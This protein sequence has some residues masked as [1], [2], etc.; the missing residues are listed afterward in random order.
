MWVR[1]IR[2]E[3]KDQGRRKRRRKMKHNNDGDGAKIL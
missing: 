3:R 1:K 2:E